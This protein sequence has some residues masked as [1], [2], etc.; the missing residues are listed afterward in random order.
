MGQVSSP[1]YEVLYLYSLKS[2]SPG[3]P[4]RGTKDSGLY[5]H[6]ALIAFHVTKGLVL[7]PY[8][9]TRDKKPTGSIPEF[10]G[11]HNTCVAFLLFDQEA[12]PL[13][14]Y[15]N[16][17]SCYFFAQEDISTSVVQT[18]R[19]QSTRLLIQHPRP[20]AQRR[21]LIDTFSPLTPKAGLPSPKLTQPPAPDT[22]RPSSL[23]RP[24]ALPSQ[25][26]LP[27][28]TI[29]FQQPAPRRADL[30]SSQRHTI[31]RPPSLRH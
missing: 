13:L 3:P 24:R 26:E 16:R 25:Q 31:R 1:T 10:E 17:V 14:A 18:H 22:S 12:P 11:M 28:P 8:M 15:Q 6:K 21:T 19:A 29:S 27:P 2:E 23:T 9:R 4:L 5:L 30:S 20:P 7:S